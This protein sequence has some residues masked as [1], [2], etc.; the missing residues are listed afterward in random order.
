VARVGNEIGWGLGDDPHG[1]P[2]YSQAADHAAELAAAVLDPAVYGWE[3][4]YTG[5]I[6][7][8][9]PGVSKATGAA[10]LADDLG[11]DPADT[12]VV[13]DGTNDLQLFAWA[14]HAVA[15]G[16]SPVEVKAAADETT[17]PVTA[18]GVALVLER[19]FG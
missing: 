16:Q 10:M 19:W 13:G 8:M 7:V 12:L 1:A 4:G 5:W 9:A 14:G 11:V 2:Q 3:I 17:L 6:D 15:M 18:D